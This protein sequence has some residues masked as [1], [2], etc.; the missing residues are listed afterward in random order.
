MPCQITNFLCHMLCIA[1]SAWQTVVPALVLIC[2]NDM[3]TM[4][5]VTASQSDYLHVSQGIYNSYGAGPH[6]KKCQPFHGS[7]ANNQ[8][9]VHFKVTD[10]QCQNQTPSLLHWVRR[11]GVPGPLFP[12]S[13]FCS[14]NKSLNPHVNSKIAL[15][16]SQMLAQNRALWMQ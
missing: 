15:S 7:G 8:P 9:Y 3:K 6:A 12:V 2:R 14:E 1:W 16:H 10:F 5:W 13:I 4:K 11:A